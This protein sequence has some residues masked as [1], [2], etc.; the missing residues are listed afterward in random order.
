MASL[1]WFRLSL[2]VPS[3]SLI[4]SA[5]PHD[6]HLI[7]TLLRNLDHPPG[8]VYVKASLIEI[9]TDKLQKHTGQ[10]FGAVTGANGIRSG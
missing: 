3:N 4:I 10:P 1:E 9:S 6:Y 2:T 5:T 8:E 7:K